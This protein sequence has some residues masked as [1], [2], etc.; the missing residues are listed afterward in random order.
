MTEKIN[1]LHLLNV[2]FPIV[3]GYSSRSNYIISNQVEMGL[4]PIV[5]T[6]P[7]QSDGKKMEFCD[8]LNYYR[9]SLLDSSLLTSVPWLR[10]I[11]LVNA[12]YKRILQIAQTEQIDVIHAHSPLLLGLAAIKAA[13]RIGVKVVYEIRAFWEDAAVASG[14]HSERSLRYRL[15]R[16]LETYVCNRVNRVVTISKAMKNEL[17]SRGISENRIFMVPNGVDHLSFKPIP[18]NVK[19]IRRHN[20]KG[21]TVFGYIGTFFDFEG[22]DDLIDAFASFHNKEEKRGLGPCWRR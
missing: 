18:K 19:L 2:S 16:K 14:K 1:V 21:K 17:I 20:L 13:R 7:H 3:C 10:E 9:S 5:L 11:L 8:G 4:N 22:I 12:V 15:V 6:S